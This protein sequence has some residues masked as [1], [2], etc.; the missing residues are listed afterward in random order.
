MG[1]GSFDTVA[2]AVERAVEASLDFAHGSWWDDSS[3]TTFRQMVQDRVG[4]V[5]FVGEHCP[6]PE[7]AKQYDGLCA[8]ACLASGQHEATWHPKLIGEQMDLGRQ[9]SSTPPQSGIPS[10]FFAPSPPAD[11][12]ERH[13]NRS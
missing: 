4:V 5:T 11:E 10:L 3:D 2:L 12:R 8:V 9:T 1:E 13:W 7:I 6:W